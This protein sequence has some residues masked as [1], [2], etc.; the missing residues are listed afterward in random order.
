MDADLTELLERFVARVSS[1]SADLTG[2]YITGSFALGAGDASSDCDFVVVTG[3][4]VDAEQERALRELHDEILGWPGYW[5][6]N[7]EGSYAPRAD[8]ATLETLGRPWLFVPRGHREMQWSPHCNAADV[9]WVLFNRSPVL[10]GRHP[11]EFACDVPPAVLQEAARPLIAGFLDDLRTWASFEISW[12]QRYAVEASSRMLYTLEHGEVIGKRAALEWA[13]AELPAEWGGL[14]KQ[15]RGD[16]FVTWNDS[17]RPGSMDRSI[18]FVEY[19]Q[20]RAAR[21]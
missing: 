11:R 13:A 14:I 6:Y 18:A 16:R 9:R 3:R 5:A 17:A 15:V 10:V 19:V 4:R 2:I 21:R 7:L 1:I 12:T 8:L 20:Q